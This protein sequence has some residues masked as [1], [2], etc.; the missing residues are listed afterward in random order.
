MKTV[1]GFGPLALAALIGCGSAS[2]QESVSASSDYP[3]VAQP[4]P[5]PPAPPPG[6]E[7]AP[8]PASAPTASP[9]PAS[10]QPGPL[11]ALPSSSPQVPSQ[12]PASDAQPAAV[13]VAQVAP[14]AAQ[15]VYSYPTGQWVF[16]STYGWIWV[17]A[18]TETTAVEDV[19]YAYL[20]TPAYG[21][22]WYVSPWGRG[23]YRYGVWVRHPWVPRGWHRA[24]VAHPRV[25]VHLG[26]RG[27]RR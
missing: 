20:Y 6:A 21:W 11:P 27:H 25:V 13:P 15:W 19:P 5:P 24:W 2:A 17:P 8:L 23:P 4:P 26:R 10:A 7:P 16:T 3:P 12:Q 18:G 14:P 22:T 1:I 9:A